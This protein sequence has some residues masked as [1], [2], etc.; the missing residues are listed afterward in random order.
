MARGRRPRLNPGGEEKRNQ[1]KN[2]TATY[3]FRQEVLQFF[4]NHTMEETLDE[5]FTARRSNSPA[6]AAR[7]VQ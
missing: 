1:F 2:D 4:A 6:A 7:R 3:Q 5:K